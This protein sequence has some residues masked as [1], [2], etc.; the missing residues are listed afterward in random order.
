MSDCKLQPMNSCGVLVVA[1]SLLVIAL[2]GCN[3]EVRKAPVDSTATTAPRPGAG[4]P[5]A[6]NT[7]WN[8]AAGGVLFLSTTPDPRSVAVVL[9]NLTDSMLV[10]ARDLDSTALPNSRVELFGPHGLAGEITLLAVSPP[11]AVPGCQSWPHAGIS[12]PPRKSWRIGFLKGR[13]TGVPLDSIEGMSSTD[14]ATFTAEITRMISSS[15]QAGDSA[16]Q[17][18]P[19]AVKKA[20]RF[21]TGSTVGFIAT[22]VRKINEEANPRQEHFLLIGEG[23]GGILREVFRTR[24]AGSE[25]SVQTNEILAF[26][27]VVE[28]GQ[29]AIAVTFEQEEGGRVGLLERASDGRWRVV[30]RSAYTGC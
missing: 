12:E 30:W 11:A 23:S 3:G 8:E 27:N 19:F 9:P 18:L 15:S 6:P 28:T 1:S 5:L 25:E 29:P 14:S 4:L 16:F 7:G 10:N 22:I 20:Y 21:S 2:S 17:G 26:V 24:T 13:V